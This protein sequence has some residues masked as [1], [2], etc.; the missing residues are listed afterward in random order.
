MIKYSIIVIS[1]NQ[2]RLT[3]RVIESLA[4]LNY[5]KEQYEVILVDDGSSP[6]FTDPEDQTLKNTRYF[7]IP[8][9]ESSSRA[10][11]RNHGAQHAV[12]D[13]IIFLD[14][15]CIVNADFIGKYEHYLSVN[16]YNLVLGTSSYLMDYQLPSELDQIYLREL[17]NSHPNSESD[18]RFHLKKLNNCSILSNIHASWLLFISRNFCIRRSLFTELGGFD[19]RFLGWGSEDIEFAY[20]LVKRNESFD[21]ISNQVFHVSAANEPRLDPSKYVSWI[22]NIG[23]F[24][25]IHQDPC[26]LLLMTQ[27]DLIFDH[28]CLGQKWDNDLQISTFQSLKSR[29]SVIKEQ[30]AVSTLNLGIVATVSDCCDSIDQFIQYHIKIGFNK[31]YLFIDDN[32]ADTYAIASQYHQV[33]A[34]LKD[35]SLLARWKETA[36]Y[37]DSTKVNLIDAEVMVRQELNFFVA[38]SLSREE[39][40]DWLVHLD[41]DELFFPNGVDLQR[42]FKDLQLKNFRSM[43]YLNF[44]SIST[45]LESPSIYLSSEHF[46]INFFKNKYWFFNQSQKEFLRDTPWLNEKFFRYYQNGKSSVSTYGNTIM[47]YDVHS[48]FGDGNRKVG[49]LQ[50]PII[51]HFPCARYSDFIKKYKRLGEFSDIWMGNKRA[52][53]FVDDI[54]LKCRDLFSAPNVTTN[55]LMDFYINNFIFD[56]DKINELILLGLAKNIR[57]HLEVLSGT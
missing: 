32:D 35:E 42:H 19:E 34:F 27:D 13:F 37:Q 16:N 4:L 12:G 7:Y 43:T 48:I 26:I 41:A 1:Y 5:E 47:F 38:Y 21:L 30:K 23:L 39:Q 44:E 18:F 45:R 9:S 52:G 24:Y 55:A 51:L 3:R 49:G 20:R 8:R 40:V 14:G 28:F 36:A 33:R 53:E 54:H 2:H 10:K 6:P 22:K 17:D 11:A 31:I 15:D 50:D 56:D 46:K 57:F 25:S 29:L